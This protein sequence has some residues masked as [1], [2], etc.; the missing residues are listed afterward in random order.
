MLATAIRTGN[1]LFIGIHIAH[2]F[3]VG[4]NGIGDIEIQAGTIRL[5]FK[6]FGIAVGVVHTGYRAI[7]RYLAFHLG[8]TADDIRADCFAN[9]RAEL[10]VTPVQV[11]HFEVRDTL[12]IFI[13][14]QAT[15]RFQRQKIG[16]LKPGINRGRVDF[17]G[18]RIEFFIV[19]LDLT[20][21]TANVGTGRKRTRGSNQ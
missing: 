16:K 10:H 1:L 18:V 13:K 2:V 4:A 8:I 12:G 11:V 14:P 15:T 3:K 17:Q 20:V 6:R 5:V 9:G 7:G 21:V 19:V